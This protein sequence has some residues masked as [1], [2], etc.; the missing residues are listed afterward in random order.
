M[1]ELA[2][3]ESCRYLQS[4]RE[5]AGPREVEFRAR[6]MQAE[7]KSFAD[8][9]DRI[10]NIAFAI[11][12]SIIET[13]RATKGMDMRDLKDQDVLDAVENAIKNIET[14][15]SGLIYEHRASS[16]RIQEVSQNIRADL[17]ELSAELIAEDRP[18]RSEVLRALR[19]VRD[20]ALSHLRRT[21]NDPGSRGYIRQM[22][23]FVPWPE[24]SRGP[25]IVLP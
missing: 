8:L 2:C 15:G 19:F 25:L 7:G 6:E 21:G 5:Q 11:E 9:N 14:E 22:A 17:D 24:E 4:A 10:L 13:Q 20:N 3:P 12:K 18:T 23:L 1:I 16:P